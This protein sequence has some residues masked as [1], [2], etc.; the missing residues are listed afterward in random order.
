MRVVAIIQARMGSTRLPGKAML[1]LCGKPMVQHIIE[2]VSRA[3]KLDAVVLAVPQSDFETFRFVPMG[4]CRLFGVQC[5]ENDLVT[6][7][8]SVATCQEAD[9]DADIIVRVCADN[10]CIEPKYIDAAVEEYL[11]KP[12]VFYSNT[13]AHVYHAW[14]GRKAAQYPSTCGHVDGLGAEVLSISRLRW[15]DKKTRG[16]NEWREHPHQYFYDFDEEGWGGHISVDFGTS[17]AD[18]RLDVNTQADY[19]FIKDIYE[20]VYPQHPAFTIEDVLTYLETM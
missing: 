4:Y 19:D 3:T 9:T 17:Y 2:R 1:P 15:L 11:S 14:F 18:L 12:Y 13:T 16:H 10:P 6:R 20:H 8:L 7:Y 5:D